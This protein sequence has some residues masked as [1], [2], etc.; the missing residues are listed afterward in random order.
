MP[1]PS[2]TPSLA[3]ENAS[4]GGTAAVDRALSLLNAFRRDESSLSLLELAERTRIHKST[5]LRLLASLQHAQLV[6]RTPAGEYR[7]GHG[8]ARLHAV[9]SSSLRLEDVVAPVLRAL[10]E[11][12]G[13]SAALHVR[14][15]DA[16]L[17]LLRVDSPQPI[18]DH[19]RIGDFLPLEHGSGGHVIQAYHGGTGPYHE[20][21][22]RD[23]VIALK[24][25][26]VGQLSGISAPVFEA[27][28]KF[29][30]A[31]TLSMPTERFLAA[32]AELVKLKA[33]E[34]SLQLG[35]G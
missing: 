27:Q 34:L 28:N 1:K 31:L 6:V 8:V 14:Q 18:R 17:C 22:R 32:Q 16:R 7:L 5:I 9:Y 11:E 29:V 24:G 12:T 3:D 35:A 21:V 30:G 23:G 2:R 33:R 4:P 20:Q 10:V 26:R 19:T 15:G 13:E 25:D